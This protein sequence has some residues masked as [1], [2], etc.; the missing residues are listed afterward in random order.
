MQKKTF[1]FGFFL[2]LIFSAAMASAAYHHGG[3]TDSDVFLSVYPDKDGTKLDNCALCHSGGQ[4]EKK[5]GQW[6]SLGSCQWCHYKYGYD[7]S[8]DIDATLNPYGRDYRDNGRNATALTDIENVDVDSDGDGY[9]NI[10]EINA[11]RYPG[12]ANDN[13]DMVS[14]PFR[15]YTREELE[16]LSQH[17]QFMLMNTHKS[18]DFYAQYT[19]VVME[20]LLKDAGILPSATNIMV[21]A[22]DGWA[23]YHPLEPDPDPLFYHVNGEYPPAVFYYDTQADASIYSEYT[24]YGWCDYSAPSC[25]GRENGESIEGL[26]MILAFKRDGAYLDPG[27]LTLDNK[28]DGEGPFRIV[29]PQKDPGPP[30]QSSNSDIQDVIWP[31]NENADHNAGFSTRSATIIRV[32]PLPEGTTDI[33]IF[34]A[35]WN[36]VDE[37]K[38]IVYGAIDPQPNI[39]QKLDELIDKLSA[40]NDEF[41]EHAG[42]KK[43]LIQKTKISRELIKNKKYIAGLNKINCDIVKKFDGCNQ[44][45]SPDKN[46]WI[47]N[48]EAQ[49]TIYWM[50]H[51]INI[52]LQILT[53]S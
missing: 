9:T 38:I 10:E 47:N 41:F 37:N 3:D 53:N 1:L 52:L 16:M 18:G 26:K 21:Y 7:A 34:E 5:T 48:C 51:E 36:F 24:G 45:G 40:L 22:P 11:L 28:L 15:I 31:F 8:G 4:Y 23:Q 39:L 50:L 35:G 32:D 27:I 42:S 19:G 17:S 30:D 25:D 33:N 49:K 43:A 29:P 20:K 12:D 44:G 2:F 14:A 6:V 13:P 46:D